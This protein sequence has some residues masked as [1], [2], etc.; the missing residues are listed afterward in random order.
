MVFSGLKN[1][2]KPSNFQRKKTLL[3]TTGLQADYFQISNIDI[4]KNPK[5][6]RI[7]DRELKIAATKQRFNK[8]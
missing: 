2:I 7:I 3:L 5:K 4:L 6:V 8:V 1:A